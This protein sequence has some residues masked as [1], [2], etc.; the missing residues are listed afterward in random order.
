MQTL[1]NMGLVYSGLMEAAGASEK[2]FEY[3]DREPA[4]PN[5]GNRQAGSVLGHVEFRDICFTYP[6]RPDVQVL[7]VNGFFAHLYVTV[8]TATILVVY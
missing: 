2:V 1:Q 8:S 4:V 7:K 6:T 3:M 5:T